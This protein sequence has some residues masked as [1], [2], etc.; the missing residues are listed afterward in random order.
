M[1]CTVVDFAKWSILGQLLSEKNDHASCLKATAAPTSASS[2]CRFRMD[3]TLIVRPQGLMD[4]ECQRMIRVKPT[5][6]CESATCFSLLVYGSPE[7]DHTL[8]IISI[9]SRSPVYLCI[10]LWLTLG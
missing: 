8:T 6:S 4:R 9:N 7:A 1:L 3:E 5:K 10:N 2:S